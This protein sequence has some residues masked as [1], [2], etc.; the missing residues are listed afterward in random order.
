MQYPK[1]ERTGLMQL[2]TETASDCAKKL[3]LKVNLPDDLYVPDINIT[4]R[5]ILLIMAS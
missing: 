4:Y 2:Q 3:D 5:H 1:P